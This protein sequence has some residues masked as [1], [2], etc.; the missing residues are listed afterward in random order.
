MTIDLT[1]TLVLLAAAMLGFTLNKPRSDVIAL[2][3]ML[4]FPLTGV[5]TLSQSLAGFSEPAVLLIALLFVIGEALVR[6]GVVYR[7]GD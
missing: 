5:L 6:T 4:L 7:L 3:L 1:I 2:L